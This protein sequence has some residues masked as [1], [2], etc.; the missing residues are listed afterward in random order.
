MHKGTAVY[1][2]AIILQNKTAKI[3]CFSYFALPLCIVSRHST[4]CA[5]WHVLCIF[6][7]CFFKFLVFEAAIYANTDVYNTPPRAAGN[8]LLDCRSTAGDASS[9]KRL[10][11]NVRSAVIIRHDARSVRPSVRQSVTRSLL[12]ART[13][14]N[15]MTALA[16][17]PP[18]AGSV[19][20]ITMRDAIFTCARMLTRVRL[21]CR[22]EPKL[23]KW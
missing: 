14:R 10:Y 13:T 8:R 12:A 11:I 21:V 16:P 22:T 1:N 23:K 20:R 3:Q 18:P 19:A 4:R 7:L 6:F 15:E 9:H 5:L 17:P 2:S